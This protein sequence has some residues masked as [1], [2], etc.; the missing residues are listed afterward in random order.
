MPN[1]KCPT[2]P[3]SVSGKMLQKYAAAFSDRH[4]DADLRTDLFNAKV[5]RMGNSAASLTHYIHD[6]VRRIYF[7]AKPE[8]SRAAL[9]S[10]GCLS[11]APAARSEGGKM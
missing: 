8:S 11:H 10:V 7:D 5:A 4:A 6:S 2:S 3:P 1:D 9:S